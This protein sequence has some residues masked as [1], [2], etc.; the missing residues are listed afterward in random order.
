MHIFDGAMGTMLQAGG[1]QEGACPEKMNLD[2]PEVVQRI[3]E[4]YLL[5]GSDIIT[6]NTFGGTRAKLDEYGLGHLVVEINTAAVNIAK[7]AIKSTQKQAKIAG[8]MGPSG[9]FISPLGS[10]TFDEIYAEYF[11][12]SKALLAAGV[13]YLL[14][15][16]IIDIQEMRAALLAA[17]DAIVAAGVG[18]RVQ[19]ICQLAFEENGRTVTGTDATS[20]AILLEAMG[21]DII[22]ANC[23]LGPEQLL[24]IIQNMI[25]HINCPIIVQP[26]AGLPILQD[27][28]TVFPLQP[29]EMKP[30]VEKFYHMGVKFMGGCC[31]TTPEHIAV[32]KNTASELSENGANPEPVKNKKNDKYTRVALTSRT[33]TVFMGQELE[34]VIIGERINPT[35]R[36][37]LAQ[38]IKEDRWLM[39]KKDALEQVEAGADILDVNMGVP[40]IDQA[41]A[42]SKAIEILSS[43]VETPLVIDS[44]DARVLEAGL[45][46]YPGRALIN[47]VN[48]EEEQM[49]QIFPLAKRYGAAVLCLP[50]MTGN[51]P[52][53]ADERLDIIAKIVERAYAHG[54]RAEDLLLDPLVLT[55]AAGKNAPSE[56]LKTLRG[57]KEQFGFPTVMGLS[58][59]SFGLPQRAYINAQFLALA[60]ENGLTSPILN[61]L[62][63]IVRKAF[64][65]AKLLLGFDE[66]AKKFIANYAN[67]DENAA[68]I[69]QTKMATTEIIGDLSTPENVI[70]AIK[71]AVEQ[72]DRENISHLVT[73]ALEIGI[74]PLR[75]TREGLS[76]AMEIIGEKF[77]SGKMFLPQVMLSAETMQEAFNKI[78]EVL[79]ASERID[80]GKVIL[81]TVKGDIHDL[82][83][84][85]VGAL[86]ENNGYTIVDLGKDVDAETIVEA[87]HRE[88]PKIVGLA[89]LMTTTM[90]QI[91]H[92]I[93]QIRKS[94]LDVKIMV[95]GAVLTP[96]YAA[97]AGA[98]RY[99][100]DGISAVKI[101]EE[102]IN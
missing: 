46:K 41:V 60:L 64:D 47:S 85:I 39:V 53:T 74:E 15:E 71:L 2:L 31:G 21:A 56:T 97:A 100:K 3:H 42:M 7:S 94:E 20:A 23:S 22:G 27:G 18:D 54:L 45:K 24:P 90:P 102:L 69:N 33:R 52:E 62:N 59:V 58:N 49:S 48:Y 83:K 96:E 16:T 82:G 43:L 99:V 29:Q 37:I 61:P 10:A 38:E 65:T 66:G 34:P 98:D 19:I 25:A 32:I 89:S 75:L 87:I 55:L 36:K 30:Y 9:K 79:P 5:A 14:I 50:L 67:D 88:Q 93:A 76:G 81:A 57:Y 6:T 92:T 91:D 1:L 78:K 72:G 101:T 28:K 95:G 13:D 44:T 80:R 63:R 68:V 26:N 17:K 86:L 12:Q 4:K 73:T 84:N 8:D 35:G 51:L 11:E 70:A 40:A 77:G